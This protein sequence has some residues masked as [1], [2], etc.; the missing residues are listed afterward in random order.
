MD[1]DIEDFAG[2][3]F[4]IMLFNGHN[5]PVL[6]SVK[7]FVGFSCRRLGMV[8]QEGEKQGLTLALSLRYNI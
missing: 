8:F 1:N 5:S 3:G 4:E 6:Q 2:I 7:L